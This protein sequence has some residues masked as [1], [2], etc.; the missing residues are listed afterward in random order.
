MIS[1]YKI[2]A[3]DRTKIHFALCFTISFMNSPHRKILKCEY[4]HG[5]L[6]GVTCALWRQLVKCSSVMPRVSNAISKNLERCRKKV[7]CALPA[8]ILLYYTIW[9][10]V[11]G[12]HLFFACFRLLV[13]LVLAD[14]VNNVSFPFRDHYTRRQRNFH[15]RSHIYEVMRLYLPITRRAQCVLSLPSLFGLFF[16]RARLSFIFQPLFHRQRQIRSHFR[17]SNTLSKKEKETQTHNKQNTG[18]A[19][20]ECLQIASPKEDQKSVCISWVEFVCV[21]LKPKQRK[22]YAA[23]QI[24][25]AP[26]QVEIWH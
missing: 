12:H 11:T 7:V 22:C 13:G 14:V 2:L 8:N 4:F 5:C 26:N 15:P 21:C 9:M 17:H 3:S 24:K 1:R 18:A 16:T 10:C 23:E 20:L 6:S 19:P 25:C